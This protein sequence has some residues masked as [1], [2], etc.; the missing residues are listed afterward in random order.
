MNELR[1]ANS[2]AVQTG[3]RFCVYANRIYW[4]DLL[5]GRK[6]VKTIR[7]H[8]GLP[9]LWLCTDVQTNI[10][11]IIPESAFEALHPPAEVGPLAQFLRRGANSSPQ[12]EIGTAPWSTKSSP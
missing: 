3:S 6:R 7:L 5:A 8:S 1:T 9:K 10:E 12:S 2:N 11:T 4:A